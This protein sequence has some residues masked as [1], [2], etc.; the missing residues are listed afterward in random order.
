MTPTTNMHLMVQPQI[1]ASN[2]SRI[3][4]ILFTI[5]TIRR[6]NIFQIHSVPPKIT[7][8]NEFRDFEWPV[9][10]E[11]FELTCDNT[12]SFHIFTKLVLDL[13]FCQLFKYLQCQS[14]Y[15]VFLQKELRFCVCC[16]FTVYKCS[17]MLFFLG[18]LLQQQVNTDTSR[19]YTLM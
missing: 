1:K 16:L 7:S 14:E 10:E 17:Y 2:N 4:F 9:L 18:K 3:G 12:C 6:K 15:Q 11:Q 5:H 19:D 8:K 13:F